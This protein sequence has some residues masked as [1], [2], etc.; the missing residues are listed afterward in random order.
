[1][2]LWRCYGAIEEECRERPNKTNDLGE[3][4]RRVTGNGA[5][6]ARSNIRWI[7]LSIIS[8]AMIQKRLIKFTAQVNFMGHI[9]CRRTIVVDVFIS[10]IY[11]GQILTTF[12]LI[13]SDSNNFHEHFLWIQNLGSIWTRRTRLYCQLL[14]PYYCLFLS[15]G[16]NLKSF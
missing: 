13:R 2:L 10:V 11:M 4:G 9:N 5:S 3:G 7:K 1:M 15:L 16:S 6:F 14:S 12:N 8:A